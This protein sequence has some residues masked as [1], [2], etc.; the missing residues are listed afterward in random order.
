MKYIIFTDGGSRGN[1]GHAAA[2]FV[3]KDEK[4]KNILKE[5]V[6]MGIGTNNE[7]EY[8]AV[9]KAL[10]RVREDNATLD[11][12]SIEFRA[13]SQLVVN[14][15]MGD[16]K[17]KNDRIRRMYEEVKRLESGFEIVVYTYIPRA[18]NFEADAMVNETLDKRNSSK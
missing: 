5:G 9:I 4:E 16:W 3:M 14:Q 7:A 10:E 13:D 18:L 8:T 17:I 12:I 6:Y 2:A 11:S 1:P 15:L